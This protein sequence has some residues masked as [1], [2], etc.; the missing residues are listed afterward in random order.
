[1]CFVYAGNEFVVANKIFKTKLYKPEL[2]VHFLRERCTFLLF[3][4][5]KCLNLI[6]NYMQYAD[7]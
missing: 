2:W 3:Y 4:S 6:R 1:M 5:K 7:I